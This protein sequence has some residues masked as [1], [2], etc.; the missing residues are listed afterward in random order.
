MV[1]RERGLVQVAA[2]P[3]ASDEQLAGDANR[4]RLQVA[5]PAPGDTDPGSGV[6]MLPGRSQSAR[7]IG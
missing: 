3:G 7:T 5:I 1:A 4:G 6:P 2:I